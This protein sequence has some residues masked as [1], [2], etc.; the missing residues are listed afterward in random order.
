MKIFVSVFLGLL[1]I[2]YMAAVVAAIWRSVKDKQ[3]KR[4][5]R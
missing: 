5:T 2:S 4:K 3:D 1:L